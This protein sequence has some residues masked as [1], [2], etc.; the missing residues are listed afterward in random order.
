MLT[1]WNSSSSFGRFSFAIAAAGCLAL[2]APAPPAAAQTPQVDARGQP[3]LGC[4]TASSPRAE[5]SDLP[6]LPQVC[7][8]P[9]AG[10]SAVDVVTV[11]N[12][13]VVSREHIDASG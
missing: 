4:W 3:W 8:V 13:K 10:T 12:S 7:V 5:I 6:G 9:A 2:A 1:T 11:N